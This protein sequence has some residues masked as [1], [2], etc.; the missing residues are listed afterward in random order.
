[1]TNV[2]DFE[3][4]T[5]DRIINEVEKAV[6]R[7]MTGLTSKL[8]SYINRVYELQTKDGTRLIAKFYRP[9]RWT[10]EALL[11][12]H[13]YILDCV[14]DEIPVISPMELSNGSTLGSCNNIYFAVFPKRLGREFEVI[15]DEDWCRLGRVI[16]RIHNAGAKQKA[17]SRIRLHPRNSTAED[18]RQLLEGG[19]ISS[20]YADAF[21]EIG[22][23]IVDISS[24]LFEDIEFT[25][26]HGDCHRGN[27]LFRP[28]EGL[29]I[30]DFDDMMTG[31]P[32]QDLWLLL[33][34]HAEKCQREIQLIL[35]GYEMFRTFNR[36]T[37]RLIE[38][39][40]AMRIIYFLAWCSKQAG[41]YQF[42]NN[43]PDWG[44]DGFWQKEIADLGRQLNIIEASIQKSPL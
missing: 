15:E 30:I 43:F 8:P 23:K 34:E 7:P 12:E 29:M 38:P 26:L 39:L 31:P 21:K 35:E 27:I 24:D 9:F 42:K 28:S 3:N 14:A 36:Q 16:A 33:P 44:S 37:I 11:E 4:L 2:A 18:I 32:I 13:G 25:R 41:D 40:R 19:F 1:M 17:H 10:K 5:P 22:N 20:K 6:D